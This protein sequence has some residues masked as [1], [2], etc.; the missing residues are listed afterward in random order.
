VR[1]SEVQVEPT[2]IDPCRDSLRQIGLRLFA[3]LGE[4]AKGG[5]EELRTVARRGANGPEGLVLG[6]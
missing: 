6:P 1:A 4:L 3:E 5:I 2:A